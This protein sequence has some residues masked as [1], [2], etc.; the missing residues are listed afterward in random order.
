MIFLY[1]SPILSGFSNYLWPLLLG[2]RDMAFPRLNAFSYWV[3]LAAAHSSFTRLP[4]RSWAERRLVQL[5]PLCREGR[6]IPA[7]TRISTR[8]AWSARHLD[9]GRRRQFH[10]HRLQDARARHVDQS[11]ADH[12][13]GHADRER[14]QPDRRSPPSASPS[15]CCG[16]I[17]SSA[18][19]S[20]SQAE[21]GQPLLWQH[22][23]WIFGHPWVYAIVLAGDGHGF[24]WAAGLLP[25]ARWSAT[26]IVA[27][28]TVATMILGFGVW[29]HHMF[30]TGLPGLSAQLLLGRLDRH[31]LSECG[32]GIRLARDDLD[33]AAG[34][35]HRL[36]V[37]RLDDR[38]VR[39]RRRFRLHDRER[40]GRLAA[41][42]HLFHRR[43][44]PLRADRHQRV[45]G[46]RRDLFLVP[47]DDRPAS[48]T[49]GSAA[50]T[51]GRCSS[52][53][54]WLPADA[55]DRAARHAAPGLYLSRRAWAG[56]RSTSSRRSAVSSSPS[57][58]CSSSSTAWISWRRACA[59]AGP[60]P[61]GRANAGMERRPSPPPPYNFAVIPTIASRHP[62][63]EDE[64]GGERGAH[65]RSHRGMTARRT[66]RRPS[67]PAPM[68]AEP[69]RI[70]PKCP[71]IVM[72][73][74]LVDDAAFSILFVGHASE[75]A[76]RWR[77]WVGSIIFGS[78][79]LWLWPRRQLLE[80]RPVEPE[81]A[82]G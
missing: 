49:S 14:R 77:R 62:L 13:L 30:A 15:S 72:R 16:W 50:G 59:F 39:D 46:R 24:G 17:A 55:P 3:Y 79:L 67:P 52:A 27:L 64:A 53:S 40:A 63:W 12:G 10:R 6:S 73:R 26:S 57:A 28:S 32:R 5:C 2:S 18:P 29:V 58:S 21:G 31:H 74:S 66:A 42:R 82:H 51:S 80:R 1:A 76:D 33:G 68:D 47:E 20:S 54:T 43:P 34:D 78:L 44:H 75:D 9:H 69:E 65:A 81:A 71:R 45:P 35:H 25:A 60:E 37:L 22:L 48:W 4:D 61:M 19:A 36:P 70:V 8:S 56:T 41:D 11:T 7:S 23:F 38:A